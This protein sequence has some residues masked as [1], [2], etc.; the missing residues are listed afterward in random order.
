M[1][2]ALTSNVGTELRLNLQTSFGVSGPQLLGYPRT[3][4]VNT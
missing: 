3:Y 4:L 2:R 1:N